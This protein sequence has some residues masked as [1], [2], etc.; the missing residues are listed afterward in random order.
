[1]LAPRI[2]KTTQPEAPHRLPAMRHRHV[3]QP[4][5]GNQAS[6][7]LLGAPRLASPP[8]LQAK[9]VVGPADDPL[10]HEADRVA[11]TVMRMPDPAVA[12]PPGGAS[13]QGPPGGASEQGS[14]GGAGAH[15]LLIQRACAA[16]KADDHA[17][18]Q[19][20]R[21]KPDEDIAGKLEDTPPPVTA[22]L[23]RQIRSLGGGSPLPGAARAFL[24]PRFGQDFSHVRVHAGAEGSAAAAAIR[25]RAFTLGPNIVFAAGQYAPDSGA[26]RHLLAHELTH[27]VQQGAMPPG[28]VQRDLATPPPAVAPAAQTDLTPAQIA[29]ALR[30]N[31][32]FYDETRTRHIQDLV[33]TQPTGAWKEEDIVA[34]AAIQQEYGLHKDGIVG[35]D[36]F[37]FLDRE[38]GAEKADKTNDNCL[39]AFNVGTDPVVAT[40]TAGGARNINAHFRMRAQ[41]SAYCGCAGYEYRQFIRGHWRTINAAGVVTDHSHDFTSEPAGALTEDFREDGNTTEG[42]VNYGHRDQINEGTG[43]GY[44]ADSHGATANQAAGCHYLGEDNPGGGIALAAGDVADVLIAFRGE[45]RRGGTPVETKFWTAVSG[46]FPA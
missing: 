3:R 16:C 9:L 14:P 7:R 28:R 22:G 40:P 15:G 11:D 31:R 29:L 38:T 26:G 41:F 33:G 39:V 34:I 17:T 23:E 10:E 30:N 5:I 42:A 19:A 4:G 46:R 13:E 24:E 18:V 8:A 25:A 21:L 35:P 43:N 6:L 1:M 20:K 12:S 36:T 44:F 45:I 27:V 37:R 32:V 2:A